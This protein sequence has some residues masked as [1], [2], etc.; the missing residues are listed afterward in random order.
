MTQSNPFPPD[1]VDPEF[2]EV[3]PV[4]GYSTPPPPSGAF[5]PTS[6]YESND[7]APDV[8]KQQAGGAADAGKH[9]AG[10]TQDQAQQSPAK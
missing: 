2:G 5:E 3:L 7:S 1:N 10:V 4:Q 9:V 6:G 8:A